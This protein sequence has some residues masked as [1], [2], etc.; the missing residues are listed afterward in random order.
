MV[1]LELY[2]IFYE[3]A[4]TGNITQ[5]SYNLN[6]SQPAVTKHIKN[7]EFQLGCS[8]F[9]RN[10]K[11]VLLN[12]NGKKLYLYVKQALSLITDG[13]RVIKR[14]NDLE[15]GKLKIGISTTLT[16]K[17]LLKY[18]KTFHKLYPNIIIEISTDPTSEL[19]EKL[20]DGKI[21]FI[22]A[23]MP[24]YQEHD[25]EYEEFGKLEDVFVV[26]KDYPDLINN[27]VTIKELIEYPILLQK[28]PSSSRE[29]IEDYFKENNVVVKSIM[30][31]A[32]SNLLIDFVK[33][34]YGVGVVTKQYV[35]EELK[36]KE[37]F[38][39]NVTPKLKVRNFGIIK[40]KDNILSKSA[41]VM[42]NLIKEEL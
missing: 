22:L 30:D 20:R 39:I 34:G 9:I 29:F 8:L 36:N 19:K 4:K 11:G 13:E 3:V 41:E 32:S 35:Q 2:K 17:F 23:K 24:G 1:D 5:A 16:K 37:L 33:I 38:E 15:K 26:N 40:L 6:I 25:L 28:Q 21:D 27:E 31:I 18:I 7:L 14:M 10:R 12:D 42:I